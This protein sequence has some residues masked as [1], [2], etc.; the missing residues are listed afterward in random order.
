M[1]EKPQFLVSPSVEAVGGS[2]PFSLIGKLLSGNRRELELLMFRSEYFVVLVCKGIPSGLGFPYNAE[3][4]LSPSG[5]LA[6]REF[7][8]GE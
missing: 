4:F 5:T 2:S 1:W 6:E 8:Q 7:L 3:I